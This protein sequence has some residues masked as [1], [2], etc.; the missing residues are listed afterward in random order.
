MLGRLRVLTKKNKLSLG[1]FCQGRCF[2]E[3][4]MSWVMMVEDQESHL[5]P[6]ALL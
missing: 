2:A 1:V 4:G 5:G 6:R 3:T